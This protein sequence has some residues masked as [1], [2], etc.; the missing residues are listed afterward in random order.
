MRTVAVVQARM[1]STRLPGKVLAPL[2]G[3]PMILRQLERLSRAERIDAI[4]VAT[5]TD[6]TDDALTEVL[7]VAGYRVHRGS[8]DDVLARF[9]GAAEAAHADVVVRITADCPLLSPAVVDRVIE[10]FEESGAHYASNTLDPT[11]PDGLDVEVIRA[12]ALK[13]LLDADLD[14]DEREHV[15]LGIYRRPNT[16]Q[17]H[18]VTDPDADR[19]NLRWTVDTAEDLEFVTWVYESFID[20]D[21]QFE[22]E[23][24]LRLLAEHPERS[25]SQADGIRNAALIG[26]D[27]GAMKGPVA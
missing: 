20:A 12:T 27:T 5:S 19:S 26:K 14:T 4:V 22:Y 10:Q 1:T 7:R 13:T 17:L 23:N 16:F 24:I 8:L 9:I 6:P 15:T 3:E 25:R 11:Y 2:A 21:P 18:S